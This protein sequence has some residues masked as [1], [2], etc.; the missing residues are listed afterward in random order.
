M[1]V[2]VMAGRRASARDRRRVDPRPTAPHRLTTVTG[3]SSR[4][5]AG[6]GAALRWRP[7]RGVGPR[8]RS[9]C[10][11]AG[12]GRPACCRTPT[13]WRRW[14]TPTTAAEPW[15]STTACDHGTAV[16]D[17]IAD[18]DRPADV[19]ATLTVTRRRVTATRQRHLT[20]SGD[21][22]PPSGDLVEVRW[23]TTS[24]PDGV[25]LHWHGVDVPNAEDGVAGVTQDAVRV[26]EEHIYRFVADQRRHLLVPLAPGLARAGRGGLF[27]AL[28]VAPR[29]ATPAVR[30][31]GRGPAQ[32]RRPAAPSTARPAQRRV[33]AAPGE[34]GPGPGRQ[35]RQ[36]RRPRCG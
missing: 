33:D 31:A 6:A 8:P 35:H 24:V 15:T 26:G 27:G 17:L 4:G 13:T 11:W 7:G 30:D 2:A 36:R 34:R 12:S 9:C 16:A 3:P 1:G 18:P 22:R 21:P 23:S 19:T 20:R 29:P 32:L 14:G 5:G 25:T 10:R 28:V